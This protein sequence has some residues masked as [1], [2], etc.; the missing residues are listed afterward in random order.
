[1]KL[2]LGLIVL[3][4]LSVQAN[5]IKKCGD[6]YG[7]FIK[8]AK[9]TVTANTILSSRFGLS[10]LKTRQQKAYAKY[11][12]KVLPLAVESS[13]Y[14]SPA[15]KVL[16]HRVRV[17]KPGN[18]NSKVYYYFNLKDQLLRSFEKKSEK[19]SWI[20]EGYKS[21]IDETI[22]N[23][24]NELGEY[25]I[26]EDMPKNVTPI[27]TSALPAKAQKKLAQL[28]EDRADWVCPRGT[29]ANECVNGAM[30]SEEHFVI[31]LDGKVIGYIF[32][33][34]DSI[35]HPLWDGSGVYHFLKASDLK[36]LDSTSWEG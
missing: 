4:S 31:K 22:L 30:D 32:N 20:C 8:G 13:V 15:D 28:I 1:M 24:A 26:N 12:S 9:R 11:S 3:I 36:V 21:L 34:Y 19:G 17:M 6:D 10:S 18:E 7:K 5:Y 27:K 33:I 25:V 14:L 16:G 2:A 23:L 29:R 35:D